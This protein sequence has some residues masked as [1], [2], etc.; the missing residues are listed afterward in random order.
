PSP[1][2][3][4]FFRCRAGM[5]RS[6][7]M[8]FPGRGIPR[9]RTCRRSLVALTAVPPSGLGVIG[10]ERIGRLST[11]RPARSPE[12]LPYIRDRA[13]DPGRRH[14]GRTHEERSPRRT[15]LAPLEV[16]VGGRGAN[17]APL[18]FV[19]V[20]AETHRTTGLAPLEPGLQEDLVEPLGLGG[21][22][23]LLGSRDDQ[24]P[25]TAR[26]AP[27]PG[28][29]GRHPEIGQAPVRAGPNEG[30]VD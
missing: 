26:D 27:T 19:L 1:A 14:H 6:V 30:D 2:K 13:R 8:S 24:G 18:K 20:H 15:P 29:L 4:T 11:R 9:P 3:V 10:T 28:D 7:S 16:P 25:D 5:I 22:R 21:P 12:H 17:L 23:D